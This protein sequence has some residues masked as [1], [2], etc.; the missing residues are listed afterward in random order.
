MMVVLNELCPFIPV[1]VTMSQNH[2]SIQSIKNA[3]CFSFSMVFICFLFCISFATC[4]WEY[5]LQVVTWEDLCVF[6]LT[7]FVV[8]VIS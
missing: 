1:P 7:A 4:L 6:I 3:S 8:R 5:R 2:G